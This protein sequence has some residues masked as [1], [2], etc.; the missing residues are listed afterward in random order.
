MQREANE[1]AVL[2]ASMLL[3]APGAL[4][5]R[6]GGD[7]RKHS[8]FRLINE[9]RS[10]F[11]RRAVQGGPARR[12]L[13]RALRYLRERP[14][15]VLLTIFAVNVLNALDGLFTLNALERGAVEANP[16]MKWA[17]Q[18]GTEPA[19]ACKLLLVG[20]LSLL[21]WRLRRFRMALLAP[22]VVGGMYSALTVYHLGLLLSI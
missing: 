16:I 21:L 14:S 9:R 18:F 11:D 15:Y 13:N 7:R 2:P 12:G 5:D 19:V 22:L 8:S 1:T 4:V 6:R 17:F 20:A 3:P 10:G